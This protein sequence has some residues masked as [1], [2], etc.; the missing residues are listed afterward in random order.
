MDGTCLPRGLSEKGAL[1]PLGLL[2]PWE[3]TVLSN[4]GGALLLDVAGKGDVSELALLNRSVRLDMAHYETV[5][6]H[7][8]AG[9]AHRGGFFKVMD[10]GAIGRCVDDARS[11]VFVLREAGDGNAATGGAGRGRIVGSLWVSLDDP[12]FDAPSPDLVAYLDGH[13]LLAKALAEG[14]VCYGRELIVA[15]DA[16]RAVHPGMALFCGAFRAMQAAGF[17]YALSEVYRVVGYRVGAEDFDADIVNEAALRSVADAGGLAI[18]RN[19][20]RVLD[21]DGGP[22]VTIE[23]VA[24]LFDFAVTLQR[25]ERR[26]SEQGVV[27]APVVPSPSPGPGPSPGHPG[28]GALEGHEAQPDRPGGERH[29]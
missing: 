19:S 9:F 3:K 11:V 21:F 23:P 27:T 14:R 2:G 25:L 18:A 22:D 12:G 8:D 10:E 4:E 28:E 13:P 15:R 1:G 6:S 29:V 24:V 5:L 26:L 7:G 16:P 17:A 20:P